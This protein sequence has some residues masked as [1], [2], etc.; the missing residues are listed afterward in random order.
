[1]KNLRPIEYQIN[2]KQ[3]DVLC[4]GAKAAKKNPQQYVMDI[5]NETYGLRGTVVNLVI[6]LQ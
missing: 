5:I 2:K 6:T 1:M 3:F 4:K